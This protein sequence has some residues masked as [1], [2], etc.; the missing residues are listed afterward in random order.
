MIDLGL[1]VCQSYWFALRTIG[2][3]LRRLVVTPQVLTVLAVLSKASVTSTF[4][5]T[6]WAGSH[7]G[8]EMRPCVQ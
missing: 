1:V 4:R 2:C 6:P 8:V 7:T 3:L 5:I